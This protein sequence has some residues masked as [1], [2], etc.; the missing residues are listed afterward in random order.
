F[1]VVPHYRSAAFVAA[2]CELHGLDDF[3]GMV[4]RQQFSR[5]TDPMSRGRRMV[6][7]IDIPQVGVLPVRSSEGM[8]LG[9]AAG[10]ALGYK[11]L[12]VHDG[13][14]VAIV[15]DGTTAEGDLHDAMNAASVWQL[16][17]LIVV[18]DNGVAISTKPEE[19]RGIKDFA[20]YAEAVG[21]AHFS[22][23]GREFL[24]SYRT[25]HKAGRVV[26]QHQRPALVHV[27]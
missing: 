8:Q 1:G 6:Y 5:G 21:F 2:W 18:T 4:L 16:P 19:G 7:H 17:L 10:W 22:C 25:L 9:K 15:G 23:D 13:I 20:A 14:A 24:E 11:K 26:R 27:H 3:S 12:D